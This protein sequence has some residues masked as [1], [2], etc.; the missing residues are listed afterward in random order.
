MNRM[1]FRSFRK[2]N[3]SQKNTSTVYSEYSHSGIVPK[4][5]ALR[6]ASYVSDVQTK[7]NWIRTNGRWYIM[8]KIIQHFFAF[9]WETFVSVVIPSTFQLMD[10]GINLFQLTLILRSA[11]LDLICSTTSFL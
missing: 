10:N 3:S 8:S 9:V 4:E 7:V 6:Y 2:R 5:C 1:I 11:T